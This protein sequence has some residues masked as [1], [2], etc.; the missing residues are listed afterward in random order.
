MTEVSEYPSPTILDSRRLTG[1]NL[2]HAAAG[3][4][5]E[6]APSAATDERITS[7]REHVARLSRGLGWAPCG[8]VARVRTESAQLFITAPLDGLMTATSLS[9]LAWALAERGREAHPGLEA[10]LHGAWIVERVRLHAVPAL[11]NA[12]IAARVN[13]CVDDEV[14]SIG[15]GAG[16]KSWRLEEL[17]A[18]IEATRAH[19]I[20]TVL[21]T[22]SNGK[23][24]T[25]RLI[26]AMWRAAGVPTGWSC[27]DGVYVD[28][29]PDV[30]V[31][32]QGD[33]TGPAGARLILRDQRVR[34]A[35]LETARGGLL[36]RGLAA[37]Q[38][39]VAVITNIS[40][41]HFG[42]Y[43]VASLE[44]LA[45]AKAIVAHALV[46]TRGVLVLNAMDA[47][48]RALPAMHVPP[49]VRAVWFAVIDETVHAD[50]GNVLDR[51]HE[52]VQQHGLGALVEHDALRVA[53][54]GVWHDCGSIKQF[55][56]TY[57]ATA[58]HNIANATASALAAVAAGV[59]VPHVLQALRTF[60]SSHTD[61]PGRLMV[62]T[63][64]GVTIVMDYAHNPDGMR[65]LCAT[66]AAMPARRRLLLLGQAGNRDDTQ[67][68]ALSA[69]AWN[70]TAFDHVIIKDMPDMLR[71]RAPAEVTDRL[72][73][74]LLHAG[75]PAAVMETAESELA[76]VRAALRW[77]QAGD[78]LVLGIH[79]DR[80]RVLALMHGLEQAGWIA[81]RPL[82][83][84]TV[85][86]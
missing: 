31:L 24:T 5:L 14:A 25:T 16:S 79:A 37:S 70:A 55:P 8:S 74:G 20:P 21:V 15:S 54:D 22:G 49:G 28:V 12:A 40:A 80:A 50:T 56:I 71:G 63:L 11:V 43:G 64:G 13:Y 6:V 41:D 52:G 82:P 2:F 81:G 45:E 34:A 69:A 61:N 9:E 44:D 1:A 84:P 36:R 33:F 68:R 35:V 86:V 72:R 7:W 19:D 65:A 57:N 53:L 26:A 27:S 85:I 10:E 59:P 38:A 83:E 58:A 62:R 39:H 17:S 66:A 30:H 47:Q 46:A 32:D 67:L 3:A 4:V 78:V 29:L 77:A 48:L 18:S 60:G 23:T 76:G 75:A 51:V 42:E 73:E